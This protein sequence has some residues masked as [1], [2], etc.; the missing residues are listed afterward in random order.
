MNLISIKQTQERLSV[1]RTF[2]ERL[3]KSGQLPV[4]RLGHRVLV[5][6]EAL[7]AFLE[8]KT[9]GEGKQLVA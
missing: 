3:I 4:V 8:K 9:A 2:V 1:S 5:S 7:D 6:D